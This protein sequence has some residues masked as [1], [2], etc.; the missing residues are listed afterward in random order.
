MY[1]NFQ[2]IKVRLTVI[3]MEVT[4]TSVGDPIYQVDISTESDNL[5]VHKILLLFIMHYAINPEDLNDLEN[6]KRLDFHDRR[7]KSRPKEMKYLT[8]LEE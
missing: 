7:L 3:T 6:L 4:S 8:K 2:F 1:L 5:E